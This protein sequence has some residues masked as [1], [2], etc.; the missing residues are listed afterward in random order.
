[1]KYKLLA[2]GAASFLA[3]STSALAAPGAPA[4]PATPAPA[5][6]TAMHTP[7]N[8][9]N[10]SAH[11]AAHPATPSLYTRVQTKLKADSL[12]TGPINGRRSEATI[13]AIRAFQTQHH[14]TSSGRLDAA[15]RQALGV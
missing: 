6:Q 12:Y 9:A 13:Q 2:L 7:T 1:M 10:A 15:T 8:T 11:A 5:A 14:L 4:S 3:L